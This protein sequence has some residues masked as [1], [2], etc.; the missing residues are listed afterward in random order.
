VTNGVI[1]FAHLYVGCRLTGM[2]F[3]W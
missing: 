1:V 3:K 2:T